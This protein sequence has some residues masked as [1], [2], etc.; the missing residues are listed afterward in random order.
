MAIT[1]PSYIY[2]PSQTAREF[3]SIPSSIAT[4]ELA[5]CTAINTAIGT[6][7][8]TTTVSVSGKTATD[9]QESMNALSSMG[10]TVSLASTTLTI[11]W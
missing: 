1:T 7:L 3:A 8:F 11:S 2:C 4:L 9:I 5:I 6:G 10:Y